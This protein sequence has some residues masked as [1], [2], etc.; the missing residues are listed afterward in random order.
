[1]GTALV[2]AHQDFV[3]LIGDKESSIHGD[4]RNDFGEMSESSMFVP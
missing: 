2:G 1:M 4:L 3:G